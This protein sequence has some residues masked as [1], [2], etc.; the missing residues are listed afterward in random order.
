RGLAGAAILELAAHVLL[1]AGG[2]GEHLV[3]AGG[4]DLRVDVLVA[5]MHGE[6]RG[7][8]LA[9]PDPRLPGAPQARDVLGVHGGP[10]LLLRLFEHDH[11]VDVAHALAL[12]GLGRAVRPYF[13]GHLAD[14]L[15]VHAGDHDLRLGG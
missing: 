13:G 2:R 15:L 9:D 3:A 4:G 8:V 6:A 1:H 12:V 11:F 14:E 5:A 10:L 7:A